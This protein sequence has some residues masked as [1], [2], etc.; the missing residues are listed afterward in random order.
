MADF[1]RINDAINEAFP[2]DPPAR[3]SIAVTELPKDAKVAV[4]AIAATNI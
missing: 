1:A 2:S 3:S 4:E